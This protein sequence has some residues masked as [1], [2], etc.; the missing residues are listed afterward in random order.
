MRY[1]ISD[2]TSLVLDPYVRPSSSLRIDP[3]AKFRNCCICLLAVM[4]AEVL[5]DVLKIYAEICDTKSSSLPQLFAIKDT[6]ALLQ[7][8]PAPVSS[9]SG[10]NS[11][12]I[13]LIYLAPN[14][15]P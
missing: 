9:M 2:S 6:G 3:I 5:L 8:K 4:I 14:T 13:A 11:H 12:V 1:F 15:M 10:S 7:L